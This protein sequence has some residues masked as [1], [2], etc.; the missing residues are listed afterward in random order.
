[1]SV[2][3]IYDCLKQELEDHAG[4][5]PPFRYA[6]NQLQ[7][8]S[9][10]IYYLNRCQSL[11]TF[12]MLNSTATVQPLSALIWKTA[13][14]YKLV[15]LLGFSLIHLLHYSCHTLFWKGNVRTFQWF[16]IASKIAWWFQ[17]AWAL[18][19]TTC[20]LLFKCLPLRHSCISP[21]A[22]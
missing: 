12:Y 5:C 4:L 11:F 20:P 16:P 10:A 13:T 6:L 22:N 21:V 14:A 3:S 8:I 2:I 19:L 15:F 9:D 18:R 17:I 7:S 1:M